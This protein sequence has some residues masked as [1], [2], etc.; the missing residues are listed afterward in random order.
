VCYSR[1]WPDYRTTWRGIRGFHRAGDERGVQGCMTTTWEWRKGAIVANS[2]PGMFYAAECSWSL[3]RTPVAD[4]ERRYAGWWLGDVRPEAGEDLDAAIIDPWP[5][6]GEAAI[7]YN[8]RMFSDMLL[9]SVRTVRM[10][11][12]LKNAPLAEA[13]DEII[14]ANQQALAR[15]DQMRERVARNADVLDYAEAAFRAYVYCGRK[16]QVMGEA[17]ERYRAA[18]LAL[19]D[20]AERTMALLGEMSTDLRDFASEMAP[21]IELYDQARA[22]LGASPDDVAKLTSQRD[23]LQSIA[24]ELNSL[25]GQVHAGEID[26]LP[27]GEQFGFHSGAYFKVG[28]WDSEQMSEEGVELRVDIS[29]HVTEPGELAIQWEYTRGAHGVRIQRAELLVNGE[30]VAEDVHPGWAGSGSRDNSYV[31]SLEQFV[32]GAKY[33]IVGW[34]ESSGGTNSY[35]DI[36]LKTGADDQQAEVHP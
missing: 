20:D 15:I 25:S 19:P 7:C 34:L 10:D 33:E 13:V 27:P 30:K 26:R 14:A 23:D 35:G 24:D 32:P 29:K 16:L 28:S 8:S 22:Q 2:L 17:T 11:F 18:R 12:A 5:R 31:L 9:A 21:L 1:M 6:S 3:G 36:W 4:F